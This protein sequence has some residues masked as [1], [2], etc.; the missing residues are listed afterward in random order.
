M[1]GTDYNISDFFFFKSADII[2]MITN[3]RIVSGWTNNHNV[4]CNEMKAK[5]VYAQIPW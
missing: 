1:D 3:I 4:S 2:S 5:E